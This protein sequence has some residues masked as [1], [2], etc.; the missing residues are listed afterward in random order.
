LVLSVSKEFMLQMKI[1]RRS[2]KSAYNTPMVS[3]S[4]EMVS[5]LKAHSY[6]FLGVALGNPHSRDP[7]GSLGKALWQGKDLFDAQG[8]LLLVKDVD[9]HGA[10]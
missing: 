7:W 6:A 10:L 2:L 1:L 5:Y 8:S 4:L 9:G 3:S